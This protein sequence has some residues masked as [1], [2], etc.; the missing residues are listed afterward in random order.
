[1]QIKDTEDTSTSK[2]KP[3]HAYSTHI[4]AS[5]PEY[6]DDMKYDKPNDVPNLNQTRSTSSRPNRQNKV[7]VHDD[8][9]TLQLYENV[10]N[11]AA[12]TNKYE[13]LLDNIRS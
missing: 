9:N 5:P 3:N 4:C 12:C 2:K 1:M 10:E 7:F 11:G 8:E 6:M 13:T